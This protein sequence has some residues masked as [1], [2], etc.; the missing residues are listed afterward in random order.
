LADALAKHRRFV[1]AV[2]H[3]LKRVCA[4]HNRLRMAG[5]QVEKTLL[6]RQKGPKQTQHHNIHFAERNR[7][8]IQVRLVVS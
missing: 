3:A 4:L 5:E 7:V 1:A 2:Q 8:A 6:F